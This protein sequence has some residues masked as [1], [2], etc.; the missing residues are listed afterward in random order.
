MK[1]ILKT[2]Q[3]IF[4]AILISINLNTVY[5]QT[6]GNIDGPNAGGSGNED[7][8][9][10][11]GGFHKGDD[12]YRIYIVDSSSPTVLQKVYDIFYEE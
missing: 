5:A 2:V 11:K 3:L 8:I 9:K 7:T 1:R 4:I 12:G 10:V 6:T